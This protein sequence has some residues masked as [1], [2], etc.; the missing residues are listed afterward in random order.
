MEQISLKMHRDSATRQE[1]RAM[2]TDADADLHRSKSN[3][4]EPPWHEERVEATKL[5]NYSP[6]PDNK[7]CWSQMVV[8]G[9]G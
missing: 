1:W 4:H 8:V 9:R 3:L 2:Q 7:V 5:E 6:Q